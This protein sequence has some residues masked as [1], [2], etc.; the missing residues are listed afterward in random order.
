M[1]TRALGSLTI[2]LLGKK[3]GLQLHPLRILIFLDNNSRNPDG[4]PSQITKLT[5]M[6]TQTESFSF[7]NY[8]S[9]HSDFPA[10][11]SDSLHRKSH[12][13]CEVHGHPSLFQPILKG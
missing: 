8:Q 4:L 10:L 13:F 11:P 1:T 5:S 9:F 7:S 12:V 3:I 2:F 6:L